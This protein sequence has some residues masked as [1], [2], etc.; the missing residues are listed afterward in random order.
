MVIFG[1]NTNQRVQLVNNMKRMK[2]ELQARLRIFVLTI[3]G[4]TSNIALGQSVVTISSISPTSAIPGDT[5]TI[6][7]TGF[8]TAANGYLDLSSAE[9]NIISSTNTQVQFTVPGNA[10]PGPVLYTNL[11]T[12]F[13]VKSSQIL[14]ILGN[15]DS[16]YVFS[17]PCDIKGTNQNYGTGEY[18][19]ANSKNNTDVFASGTFSDFDKDGDLDFIKIQESVSG[20][21]GS[22]LYIWKNNNTTNTF[23]S[24]KL[25]R[26]EKQV[27]EQAE[28]VSIF[29]ANADGK[30]D[31]IVTNG[32]SGAGG[33]NTV[34]ILLNDYT[35]SSYIFST[36]FD[37]SLPHLD[38]IR[39]ADMTDDGLEDI[40][41]LRDDQDTIVIYENT[42]VVGAFTNFSID[43]NDS[44]KLG[45]TNATGGNVT[46]YHIEVGDFNLDGRQDIV[47]SH[48]EGLQIFT[49]DASSTW[50]SIHIS[51][52]VAYG[53]IAVGDLDSDGKADI[54]VSPVSK[55]TSQSIYGYINTYT[56]GTLGA[57]DFS[58]LTIPHA[59][60]DHNSNTSRNYH[61]S[62]AD[63]NWDGNM[64]IISA[65]LGGNNRADHWILENRPE[66]LLTSAASTSFSNAVDFSG[67][68][69]RMEQVTTSFYRS[70][71]KMGD[72]GDTTTAPSTAGNT[73]SDGNAR[74]WATSIVFSSDKDASNQHIWNV[75]EGIA[76]T[77]DNIYLRTDSI[78]KLYFG[79]GRDG[80]LNECLIHPIGTNSNWT[81]TAGNW[82]GIYIAHNGT[83]LSGTDA[84][85]ANLA[86]AFD[87]RLMD[88]SNNW[89]T[90]GYSNTN[91]STSSNWTSG[92]TGG[93]M[94]EKIQGVVSI[95]GVG[96]DRSFKGKVAAMVVT[97]L[98]RNVAMP[99]S[100]E[101]L[102][103]TIDPM[104]WV[105]SY[106]V[107]NAFRVPWQGQNMNNFQ[108]G[109][110]SSSYG[111]QVWLMGDGSL[112][113][114]ANNIRNQIGKND[115]NYTRLDF[116]SMQSNDIKP[117]SIPGSSQGNP[118]FGLPIRINT[119]QYSIEGNW[120]QYRHTFAADF[121]RDSV[122]D[123]V[124]FYRYGIEFQTN[125]VAREPGVLEV[126]QLKSLDDTAH[127]SSTT[128]DTLLFKVY[129]KGLNP[130]QENADLKMDLPRFYRYKVTYDSNPPSYIPPTT[131]SY[132]NTI[133]IAQPTTPQD[134][135]YVWLVAGNL[136]DVYGATS[137][138][139]NTTRTYTNTLKFYFDRKNSSNPCRSP[140]PV[141][142]ATFTNT[143][144]GRPTEIFFRDS[145]IIITHI[146]LPVVTL[147]LLSLN[148]P[149]PTLIRYYTNFGIRRTPPVFLRVT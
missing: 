97:T 83:R 99:D 134:T 143:W 8:A 128:G 82:Y 125:T 94:A 89:A 61:L 71:L 54:I 149:V 49:R 73:S 43:Q 53:F 18:V 28:N 72:I 101:I 52:T 62:L 148:L 23:S 65:Q 40:I 2:A 95:G 79:W 122:P 140:D 137:S 10:I 19:Q 84:T 35:T 48:S 51:S 60:T 106:K 33:A 147:T 13:T 69:E 1:S 91:L 144:L 105:N 133:T 46:P 5:I 58:T 66:I 70:A 47:V 32:N 118:S 120:P 12:N 111:T 115:Q 116:K 92:S 108:I 104:G 145:Q 44:T 24:S 110:G 131:Y 119:H 117:I 130:D 36:T 34:S 107:G 132:M 22:V 138:T 102:K 9:A 4:I 88:A 109:D 141:E 136:G 127:C 26:V 78:G 7:G 6:T 20:L 74:P 42:T 114:Y 67:G 63:I 93:S 86:A 31:L 81:L 142:T 100:T 30:Q 121:N 38:M 64:D 27:V 146:L 113:S 112:D 15:T 80:A 139:L 87:I 75:G 98:R 135:L 17:P 103:M 124:S 59:T 14:N 29:D 57:S 129:V 39:T 77:H 16:S 85:A 50:S 3:I 123:L 25:L 68:S 11:T 96:A 45:I 55:T 56:S 76:S 126:T 37:L 90:V 41:G 21:T